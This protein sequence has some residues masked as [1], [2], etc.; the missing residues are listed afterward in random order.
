MTAVSWQIIVPILLGFAAV[1]L[2]VLGIGRFLANFGFRR[3]VAAVVEPARK[4]SRGSGPLGRV[5]GR[6]TRVVDAVSKLSVPSDS[7]YETEQRLQFIRAGL[8]NPYSARVF[9]ALRASLTLGLP[10]IVWSLMGSIAPEA[11]AAQA[12]LYILLAAVAGYYVPG[13]WL[14]SRT[15]ARQA[16]IRDALPD[17]IDLLVIC[18]ESGLGMDAAINRVSREM[19][20]NSKAL[21]EEFYL[22]ALETRAGATRIAALKNLARRVHI[23]DLYDLV[24]ML[25]QADKFGTSLGESLRIQADI[26]RIKRMQ[27]AEESAAKVP[28]K[29]LLPLVL[30]IFPVLMIVLIGPA[31]IQMMT[32]MGGD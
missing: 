21:A 12:A 15:S 18:A 7:G 31:A 23:D 20:R 24:A 22:V 25:V 1:F 13:M 26:M 17:M 14:D 32:A 6:W 30:L 5:S 8:R 19:A 27:R 9:H 3:R 4:S 29:M 28:A 11:T 16:E 10:A 2:F